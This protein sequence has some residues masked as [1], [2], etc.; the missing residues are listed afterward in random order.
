MGDLDEDGHADFAIGAPGTDLGPLPDAGA[1]LV[2][3]GNDLFLRTTG[4]YHE[5]G[6]VVEIPLAGISVTDR[7][8]A[9]AMA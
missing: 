3:G 2:L 8:A 1:V 4:K 5:A 9:K 7:I 6:D